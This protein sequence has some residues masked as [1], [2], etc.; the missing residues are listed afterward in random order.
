MDDG[1]VLVV[2]DADDLRLLV[3]LVLEG[4]GRFE[5]VGE[6]ATGREGIELARDL[7]PDVVMLDVSMP[8]IDG[9]A[10]LPQILKESPQSTVVMFSGFHHAGVA[11]AATRLGA[12]GYIEKEAGIDDLVHR[13]DAIL[14]RSERRAPDPARSPVE[15][16]APGAM[17][18]LADQV[19]RFQDF[20]DQAAIGLG[21]LTLD[22]G[23]VRTNP[24]FARLVGRAEAELVGRA[25]PDVVDPADRA[26]LRRR[27]TDLDQRPL[28]HVVRMGEQEPPV[29]VTV[30]AS[31]VTDRSTAPL[32]VFVQLEDITAHRR[33]EEERR[34]V[35][36][37]A[38]AIADAPTLEDAYR[39]A[40]EVLC[41]AGGWSYG[42]AWIEREDGRLTLGPSW[43]EAGQGLEPFVA[44]S[45]VLAA[46]P[47]EGFIGEAW[48]G[49]EPI[50]VDVADEGRLLRAS[51]ASGA[52]LRRALAVPVRAGDRV[53]AV[54]EFF[55][56]RAH[57]DTI[58]TAAAV[59]AHELGV[60]VAR[61]QAEER[62][63]R[64]SELLERAEAAAHLGSWEWDLAT[65]EIRWSD[66]LFRIAG[67]LPQSRTITY[68][69]FTAM[70]HPDDRPAVREAGDVALAGG[71]A[72]GLR[73]RIVRPDG[74]VRVVLGSTGVWADGDG[75]P[76]RLVGTAQ[77]ITDHTGAATSAGQVRHR[78]N[79][80]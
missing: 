63:R 33:A 4:S 38:A 45:R 31:V 14:T 2:D 37:A 11:D 51:A 22:L 23:I 74:T 50:V 61:R 52:G 21:V 64:A 18:V 41:S 75:R 7:Q 27:L 67:L 69:A 53:V 77:D 20:F 49:T 56:T 59:A 25:L 26:E 78:S 8:D 60:V 17:E 30:T 70:V 46:R 13:L 3:R 79:E 29:W 28:R 35:L 16:R 43:H 65:G 57:L 10:A 6:G 58:G 39:A 19:E 15:Q 76:V 42:G 55:G 72:S 80:R 73:Y 68:E 9:L 5:V 12:A 24:A 34:L 71:E 62:Q 44:T 47:G 48:T 54:L 40:L 66:E 1:R 32:Y 36:R